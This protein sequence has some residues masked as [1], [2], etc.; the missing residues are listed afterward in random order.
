MT[1][2]VENL[3]QKTTKEDIEN[4]IREVISKTLQIEKDSIALD[5]SF[6]EDLQLDSLDMVEFIMAIETKYNIHIP[7]EEASKLVTVKSV[8]EYIYNKIK[9]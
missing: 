7:D 9:A 5:L 2:S 4:D 3:K 8:V 6:T 1:S